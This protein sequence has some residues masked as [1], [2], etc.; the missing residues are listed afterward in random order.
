MNTSKTQAI[1]QPNFLD[2]VVD[3]PPALKDKINEI[4]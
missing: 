1:H 3:K 2:D 4:L